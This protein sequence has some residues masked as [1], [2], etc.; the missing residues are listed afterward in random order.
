MATGLNIIS[1]FVI[2]M[3]IRRRNGDDDNKNKFDNNPTW[4]VQSR[5]AE[6]EKGF[7]TYIYIHIYGELCIFT[8]V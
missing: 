6:K 2:Q 5:I 3:K 7:C 4:H 1:I 8:N